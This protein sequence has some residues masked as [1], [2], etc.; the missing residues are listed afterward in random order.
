V[1]GVEPARDRRAALQRMA[2]SVDRVRPDALTDS[3]M[4]EL[5]II[6]FG[7]HRTEE[8]KRARALGLRKIAAFAADRREMSLVASMGRAALVQGW[9]GPI[10]FEGVRTGDGRLIGPDALRAARFPLP[11]RWA[12]S[13]VGGHDGAVVVGLIDS[14][15]RLPDGTIHATGLLDLGSAGGRE[16][17]RQIA[18]GFAGGISLDLDSTDAEPATLNGKSTAVTTS[19]RIRAAT[20][21]A[22]PAFDGAR[23]SLVG[24]PRPGDD[25]GCDDP[26]PGVYSFT[27]ISKN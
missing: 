20:V 14:L 23:I 8:K 16:V 25:C 18:G 10:G 12:A 2:A 5:N 26:T 24:D 21:V 15:T 22:V 13:D 1:P 17:T 27:P 6:A 11:L 19:A 7:Y 4:S 3:E 9:A